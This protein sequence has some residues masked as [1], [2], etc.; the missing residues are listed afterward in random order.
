[1]RHLAYLLDKIARSYHHMC[2]LP[3]NMEAYFE[4]YIP[5]KDIPLDTYQKIFKLSSEDLE[6]V[7]KEGYNAYLQGDYEESSTAF[8]WLIF[9]NPFVS[10]FWFFIRSFAPYA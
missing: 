10:K 6:Q 9:F 2:P 1:M 7:Y 8:Y 3:D 4:N 5:N